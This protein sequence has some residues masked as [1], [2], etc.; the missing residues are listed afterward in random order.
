MNVWELCEGRQYIKPLSVEPWRVVEA[1]H[2]LSSRDLVDSREE[3]DL[4]EE[5][6]EQSKPAI[7]KEK[8][9]LIFTPFRY[10]PLKYGSRF[11]RTFE[12]SLWY[13][14]KELETAFTEVAYYRLKF[15]ND[16]QGD[17]GYLE[18]SMTAFTAFLTTQKGLDLT[19]TPFNQYIKHISDKNDYA[20]S[21]LLGSAMRQEQVEA[22][23]YPSA[24]T[25]NKAKNIA[26]Y[27]PAVFKMKNNQ[28]VNNQQTWIC[29]ASK[30]VIEFTRM[31]ILGKERFSFG[32]TYF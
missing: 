23:I 27:T 29:L 17:L 20:Y 13:G 8:N 11:G 6:L 24:R 31:G 7:E 9:Y 26:A 22:F 16:S 10:P 21:Q 28:Y 14:S 4:L 19:E 32:E 15:L 18:I 12:P 2:I 5:L 1:Q 25:A 3:H 30:Q